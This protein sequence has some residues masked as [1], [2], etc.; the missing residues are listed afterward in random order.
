MLLLTYATS[1]G[2]TGFVTI[3]SAIAGLFYAIIGLAALAFLYWLITKID[4]FLGVAVWI[5]STT[6]LFALYGV[7]FYFLDPKNIIN[8]KE[9]VF[10]AWWGVVS[11]GLIGLG[12]N[13]L[14]LG[15][16]VFK[17]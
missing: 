1:D 2:T 7:T 8:N 16:S 11:L 13:V 15:K 17:R 4:S 5:G 9:I 6:L 14:C 12:I 10:G 3:G